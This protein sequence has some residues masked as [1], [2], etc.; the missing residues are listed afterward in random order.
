M[1]GTGNA[2]LDA[3]KAAAS[4]KS[5]VVLLVIAT[6]V[7][8]FLPCVGAN[9]L[10]GINNSTAGDA[11]RSVRRRAEGLVDQTK[12]AAAAK[13]NGPGVISISLIGERH[14]GTNWITD[15]LQECF[16]DQLQVMTPKSCDCA[17]RWNTSCWR[18]KFQ[19]LTLTLYPSLSID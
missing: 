13:K 7:L 2:K 18:S 17:I 16:G 15:H 3:P 6:A 10:R 11:L 4:S 8:C 14:S 5:R 1:K 9:T 12:V 19:L